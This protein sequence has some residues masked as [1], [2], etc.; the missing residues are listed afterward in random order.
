[1]VNAAAP[2]VSSTITRAA[3]TV[4]RVHNNR[5]QRPAERPRLI[6]ILFSDS[7]WVQLAQPLGMLAQ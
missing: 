5:D 3:P 1:V 6:A 2:D 4:L 7:D